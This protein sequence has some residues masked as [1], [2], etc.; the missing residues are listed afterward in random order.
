VAQVL[1][2]A[3]WKDASALVG[4]F[5]EWANAGYPLEA[6]AAAGELVNNRA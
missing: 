1:A 5:D 4:G 3:G 6:K 2:D